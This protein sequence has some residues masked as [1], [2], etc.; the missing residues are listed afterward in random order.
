MFMKRKQWHLCTIINGEIF[1]HKWTLDFHYTCTTACSL[2]KSQVK[3][4]NKNFFNMQNESCRCYLQFAASL[5]HFG[6]VGFN[7]SCFIVT[8]ILYC[9]CGKLCRLWIANIFT[10]KR[11]GWKEL[12]SVDYSIKMR[13]NQIADLDWPLV[14]SG[15][16]V[17]KLFQRASPSVLLSQLVLGTVMYVHCM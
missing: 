1:C 10:N 14:N 9:C 8:A 12:I 5:C 3:L 13:C 2:Q 15:S 16:V 17:G 6:F 7:G 11:A 4:Q